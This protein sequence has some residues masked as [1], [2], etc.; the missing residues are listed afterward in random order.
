MTSSAAGLGSRGTRLYFANRGA[1]AFQEV[2]NVKTTPEIGATSQ[3]IEITNLGDENQRFALGMGSIP[4]L[5]FSIIYKGPDWNKIYDKAGNRIEYDWKLVYPD[6]M[7]VTFTGAFDLQLVALDINTPVMYNLNIAPNNVPK[8]HLSV[9]DSSEENESENEGD[10][11]SYRP[12]FVKSFASVAEMNAFDNSNDDLIR[13]D[14]VLVN[15]TD[16]DRGK[17]YFYNDNGFTFFANI[18]GPQG[19]QGIKG[20]AGVNMKM[21]GKEDVLPKLANEGELCFV[22]TT[23]Y[24]YT[25]GKWINLGDFK[26]D[27]G[28]QGEVGPQGPVGE[29]GETGLTGIQGP[30]GDT[31]EQGPQG[32]QGIQGKQ[33]I[34]GIPGIQGETGKGF[35][36]T[37]TFESVA[38][39]DGTG[40][41]QGDF[42]IVADDTNDPDNGRLYVWDGKDFQFIDDISGVQGIQGETG[43]QGIP[44]ETGE[45]GKP[46]ADGVN[47]KSA[48]DLAVDAGFTGTEAEWR[49]SLKGDPGD[50]QLAADNVFTGKNTFKTDPVDKDGVPYETSNHAAQTYE[51]IAKVKETYDD[52]KKNKVTDNLD[53]TVTINGTVYSL[54]NNNISPI[55]NSQTPFDANSLTTPGHY[56]V[57]AASQFLNCPPGMTTFTVYDV[58]GSSSSTCTQ[59]ATKNDATLAIRNYF[60]GAGWGAW[61]VFVGQNELS[62]VTARVAALEAKA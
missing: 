2:A 34:Q 50:V 58:F 1:I 46:G 39:L 27:K 49:E 59:I 38:A 31:G 57:N 16:G 60:N 8:F 51:S 19:V 14:F 29:Q 40:L 4:I 24:S 22:G 45:T 52:L 11:M 9:D 30:K 7:F 32:E 47:G 44:G 10:S 21:L 48:Y 37:K 61:K 5:A 23:L 3:Q 33:G 36:I 62:L 54:F 56:Q 41:S 53:G 20:D 17:V 28:D 6:G 18:I 55:E 25:G 12:M 26:G 42:V 35:S 13:G 43:P 15:S